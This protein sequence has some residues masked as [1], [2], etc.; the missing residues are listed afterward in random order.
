MPA[1]FFLG[2]VMR[3]AALIQFRVCSWNLKSIEGCNPL[4]QCEGRVATLILNSEFMKL[5]LSWPE[6]IEISIRVVTLIERIWNLIPSI[7]NGIITK[8]RL[9]WQP[10]ATI[11]NKSNEFTT[12]VATRSYEATYK[13]GQWVMRGREVKTRVATLI[14]KA[15]KLQRGLRPSLKSN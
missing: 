9:G 11:I 12:R 8:S 14:E 3:V 1:V 5:C 4:F 6:T 7:S 13:G 10:C 2:L 15:M